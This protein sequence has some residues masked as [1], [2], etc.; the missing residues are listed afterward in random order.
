[1]SHAIRRL[2]WAFAAFV[3]L[4]GI[5][6]GGLV[7]SASPASA[8]SCA[9]RGHAYLT[10]PV[11]RQYIFS[12]YEGDQS[13]G[14]R[15]VNIDTG[16]TS[17]YVNTGGNGIRPG[18]SVVFNLFRTDGGTQFVRGIQ[19]RTA[20]SSCVVN[21]QRATILDGLDPGQYV[22]TANYF[23]GGSGAYISNDWV[24]LISV[25]APPPPPVCVYDPDA[26]GT[27][28]Y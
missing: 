20:N 1:M 8:A 10:V 5:S 3:M 22:L 2:R 13:V 18:S 17:S 16:Q 15:T 26:G 12:G 21:E 4:A 27:I 24:V 25:Q 9:T 19:T 11:L 28:C 7:M 23:A 14:L 6:V